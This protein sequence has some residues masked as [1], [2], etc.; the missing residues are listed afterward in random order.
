MIMVSDD[1]ID[2]LQ[3]LMDAVRSCRSKRQALAAELSQADAEL[4]GVEAM[5]DA[6]LREAILPSEFGGFGEGGLLDVLADATSSIPSS[7]RQSSFPKADHDR[8]SD[9]FGEFGKDALED[10]DPAEANADDPQEGCAEVCRDPAAA[11]A[12]EGRRPMASRRG[13]HIAKST[14]ALVRYV[15]AHPRPDYGEMAKVVAGRD[16]R[17]ARNKAGMRLRNLEAAGR[18]RF[19]ADGWEVADPQILRAALAAVA[20]ATEVMTTKRTTGKK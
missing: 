3:Q 19:G 5:L 4:A 8:P 15:A 20:P 2:R 18:I 14:L 10:T 7:P 6:T 16:D 17:R 13:R 9:G 1:A 11:S 12:A